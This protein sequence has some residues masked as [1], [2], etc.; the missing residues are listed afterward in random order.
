MSPIKTA[1]TTTMT[2]DTGI[3]VKYVFSDLGGGGDYERIRYL[4]TLM[5][6]SVNFITDKDFY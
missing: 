1:T 5:E 6:Y 3:I 4:M 2:T